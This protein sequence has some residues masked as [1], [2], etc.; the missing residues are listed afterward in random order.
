VFPLSRSCQK[1]CGTGSTYLFGGGQVGFCSAVAIDPRSMYLFSSDFFFEEG[2][3][4]DWLCLTS[5]PYLPVSG[6]FFFALFGF[7]YFPPFRRTFMSVAISS[8]FLEL[9]FLHSLSLSFL[10]GCPPFSCVQRKKV[11]LQA[12]SLVTPTCSSPLYNK[13]LLFFSRPSVGIGVGV[14]FFL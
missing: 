3:G 14:F 2:L 7:V 12:Y 11:F 5:L 10:G 4:T 6:V 13:N 9:P 1:L 8:L